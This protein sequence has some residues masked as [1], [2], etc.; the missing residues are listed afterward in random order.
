[1][2]KTRYSFDEIFD[3]NA[4]FAIVV[5]DYENYIK[6][7]AEV[8]NEIPLKFLFCLVAGVVKAAS[9]LGF[10]F[11]YGIGV[12]Q[13]KPLSHLMFSVSS[14]LGTDLVIQEGL[15]EQNKEQ[16][17]KIVNIVK[18]NADS[19]NSYRNILQSV[20]ELDK[21][22]TLSL[23]KN[24]APSDLKNDFIQIDGAIGYLSFDSKDILNDLTGGSRNTYDPGPDLQYYEVLG[25]RDR[26]NCKDNVE[27]G[28]EDSSFLCGDCII[29]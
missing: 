23:L 10:C 12:S 7:K 22:L 15:V 29:F 13:N 25:G 8:I 9:Y 6:Q 14:S 3:A 27:G 18:A 20:L 16:V 5:E 21:T 17:E 26:S 2:A 1:M 19:N 28:T 11:D 24:I 4:E